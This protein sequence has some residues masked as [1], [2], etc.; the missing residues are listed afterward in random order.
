MKF[1]FFLHNIYL[2]PIS[3]VI[4][5]PEQADDY[6]RKTFDPNYHGAFV[7]TTDELLYLNKINAKKFTYRACKEQLYT[8][9][10]GLLFQKHSFLVEAF[11]KAILQ[12]QANGL[13]NYW[14]SK[15]IDNVYLNVPEPRKPAQKLTIHQLHGTFQMLV[16]G[17][18]LSAFC[19]TVEIL[20]KKI[21]Q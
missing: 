3:T 16:A 10:N 20:F 1:F 14:I 5:K 15:Y 21:T 17:H 13:I 12:L 7:I 8:V 18:L 2:T 19:F 4:I 6:K 11:N 9:N